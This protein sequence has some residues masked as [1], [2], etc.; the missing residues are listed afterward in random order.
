MDT[1][2]GNISRVIYYNEENGYGVVK[3]KLDGKNEQLK[4]YLEEFYLTEITVTSMFDREPLINEDYEFFGKITMNDKYGKQFMATSYSRKNETLEGVVAY[5]SSDFFM[6]VGVKTAK[7]IYQTLGSD[8]LNKIY[9]NKDILDSVITDKKLKDVIYDGIVSA[10]EKEKDILGL[11][12]LGLTIKM[13]TKITTFIPLDSYQ[14]VKK[15]PY[16]LIDLVEGIGFIK[17]DKIALNNGIKPN[18]L[19]RIEAFIKFYL[20][21]LIHRTGDAYIEEDELVEKLFSELNKE[22]DL[23]T[24]DTYEKAV[25]DLIKRKKIFIDENRN[26]Y[27]YVIYNN[28]N[29]VASFIGGLLKEEARKFKDKDIDLALERIDKELNISYS[30]DQLV[31]IKNALK[32]NISIITGGPGTGKTTIIRGLIEAYVILRKKDVVREKIALLAP[33][34]R[35]A[36]RLSEVTS[37]PASTI[38]RF[39]GYSSLGFKYG[40]DEKVDSELVIIDE[41]SMVDINLA[42]HLFSALKEKTKVVIVGDV[43]QL[44]SIG[45]GEVLA[46]MIESHEITSTTLNQ[47]YRQS[48]DSSIISFAHSI[49]HGYVPSDILEK[50]KDRSF[51]NVY[52]EYIANNIVNIVKSAVSKGLNII[53]DIQVLIPIYRGKNGIDALNKMIQETINPKGELFNGVTVERNGFSLREKDKVIQLVNRPDKGVMNGDIGQIKTI[54]KINNEAIIKVKFDNGEVEYSADE[55]DDLKLA[56]AISIHKAQGSE[57]SCAIVPFSM[58]YRFM[59]RRKLIYTA[60]TRA[61]N[62]LVMLGSSEALLVGV[63]GI[64]E[65][66]KTRLKEKIIEVVNKEGLIFDSE[67][68]SNSIELS[69]FDFME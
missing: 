50:K 45:P 8:C 55:F 48:L 59:L 62:Y 33:T 47:I 23:I 12:S 20:D 2:Y 66:R 6:G 46:N 19:I 9:D 30:G 17:A 42:S 51:S 35:A 5:L 7:K 69:P 54:E 61:K 37:H 18:S 39:L 44:P 3:I 11:M 68:I 25:K 63:Q 58:E 49:N 13:A 56:Y 64:E 53:N 43:N 15:N 16:I 22:S 21:T 41:F 32:E 65:R 36:K 10:K 34:G 29:Y 4:K 52:N 31:A 38:H 14:K 57:F 26:V 28:E 1:I 60:V 67:S 27:P 24:K 40:I